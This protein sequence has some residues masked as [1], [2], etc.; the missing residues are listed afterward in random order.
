[1]EQAP[2]LCFVGFGE[3][4]YHW[5]RTLTQAAYP[6]DALGV[7]YL[8]HP[9]GREG[10]AAARALE[11]GIRLARSPAEVAP[12][13]DIHIHAT[14]PAVAYE[15]FAACRSLLRP[16]KAWID[17]N[18]TGPTTKVRMA[19]DA[20]ACGVDFVDGAIMAP[21]WQHGHRTPVWQSGT[22]T[23]R[24]AAWGKTWGTPTVFVGEEAGAAARVKMCRSVIVKG[25]TASLVE[26]L[27]LAEMNGI[28]DPVLESLRDDFGPQ[29]I[30]TLCN[31]LI[32][33]TLRHGE[34]RSAEMN[35][36]LDL[37]AE[38]HWR[39]LTM[40]STAA[41]LA[42]VGAFGSRGVVPHADSYRALLAS[43]AAEVRKEM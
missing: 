18:S 30:D 37:A 17:L 25:I 15:I 31:R 34:R 23:T 1:M 6:R 22:G 36:A 14:A 24:F 38:T 32:Q 10:V 27:L 21:A 9:G 2:R 29:V 5:L 39:P 8:D 13:T 11:L 35:G 40:H 28:A 4:T 26:G 33:G 7:L 42:Y 43:L 12:D 41:L 20:A 19:V 3:V 16:G